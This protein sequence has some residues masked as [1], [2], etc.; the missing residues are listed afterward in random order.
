MKGTTIYEILMMFKLGFVI[1]ELNI[2]PGTQV[3]VD[4]SIL[5]NGLNLEIYCSSIESS[6]KIILHFFLAIKD[7]LHYYTYFVVEE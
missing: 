5:Q 3:Y 6:Q 1:L 2:P 4:F 7:V